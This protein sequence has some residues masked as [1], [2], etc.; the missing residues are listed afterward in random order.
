MTTETTRTNPPMTIVAAFFG[1]LASTVSA[2]AGGFLILNYRDELA[3][4]LRDADTSLSGERLDQAVLVAQGF[5]LA[6]VAVVVLTYLWLSFKLK[7]GRNWARVALTVLT[8]LHAASLLATHATWAGYLSCAVAVL[9]MVS[10]YLPPS[11]A[12]V[13]GAGRTS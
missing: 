6:V 2:L 5:A 1:F 9:A 12:Y 11:N 4:T 13:A 3:A 8:L 7:A 10:S